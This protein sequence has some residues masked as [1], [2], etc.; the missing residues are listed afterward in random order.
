M[1]PKE[2]KLK[3]ITLLKQKGKATNTEM[4]ELLD[5]E[6]VL[7]G[8]IREELILDD[9]AEDKKGVGL[10][11][12]NQETI[13]ASDH[14]P[15]NNSLKK[16]ETDIE[17][18]FPDKHKTNETGQ[19]IF[20]SYGRQDAMEFAHKLAID[21]EHKANRQ[22]WL[23]MKSI[24]IGGMFEV[25]IEEGIR[26]SSLVLAVMTPHSLREESICRDEVVFALNEGKAVVPI[27]TG[28][29]VKPPLLLA[30]R[31]WI[32][33]SADYEE[34]FHSLLRFLNGDNL[35]LQQ[36]RL[37]SVTGV[38]PYD[39]GPEIARYTSGFT[40]REW[41][42]KEVE[43]WLINSK[44]RVLIII[45][46]P[47][48]GKSSI[49]AWISHQFR[50]QV[51]GIHFC[52]HRNTRTLNVFEFV[53]NI[54]GQL[55][56]Q[57]PEYA[58][59]VE[60][61]NPESRR[62]TASDA[63][64]ELVIEPSR[65]IVRPD[66]TYFFIVDSL[67]EAS[68]QEGENIIDVLSEQAADLPD[69]LKFFAT[70]RPE[71]NVVRKIKILNTY[72]LNAHRPENMSDVK[73]YIDNKLFELD[74]ELHFLNKIPAIS[75]AIENLAQGNFLYASLI[76]GA[77]ESKT[78]SL[79]EIGELMPGLSSY[80]DKI[81]NRIFADYK[82][83]SND[84]SVIFKVLA[85]SLGPIPA[86]L[87]LKICGF[88]PETL[89]KRLGRVKSFLRVYNYGDTQ[90]Y[91]L[92]HKSLADWLTDLNASGNYWCDPLSAFNILSD[93]LSNNWEEHDYALR[94]L[95]K[96][97]IICER[98]QELKTLITNLNFIQK[99]VVA[100][101]LYE[102]FED[103]SDTIKSITDPETNSI[104][105]DFE[106]AFRWEM[107]NLKKYPQI[108][109]QSL[110]NRLKWKGEIIA[111]I[112][113]PARKKYVESG[114]ILLNQYRIPSFEKTNIILTL[115]GHTDCVNSC[116]WSPDN[117]K[118]VTAGSDAIL[119]I[120]DV[121]NGKEVLSLP[122]HKSDVNV[123]SWSPSGF[124]IASAGND[125]FLRFWDSEKGIEIKSIPAHESI[126]T[127]LSWSPDGTR[128]VTGSYDRNL[129]IWDYQTGRLKHIL[130][131]H[132]DEINTCDWSK[133]GNIIVSA[134]KDKTIRI[135]NA[136]DGSMIKCIRGHKKN[137]LS[138]SLSPDG[139]RIATASFD[140][141]LKIWDFETGKELNSVK[142][143]DHVTNNCAWSPDGK[144]I[145]A[146]SWKIKIYL[147][148]S[149]KE[150]GILKGHTRRVNSCQWS[151][152]S[153]RIASAGDEKTLRIWDVENARIMES[154]S[155]STFLIY[156]CPWSPDGETIATGSWDKTVT[157]FEART[158]KEIKI[159]E[160]HT[161][162]VNFCSWSPMGD[163]LVSGSID[164]NLIIWDPAKGKEELVLKGHDHR[165]N[166]CKYSSDG[167]RIVS[168]GHDKVLKIWDVTSGNEIRE[169]TGH[170]EPV[171]SCSWSP[172]SKLLVSGD[173]NGMIKLWNVNRAESIKSLVKHEGSVT[174]LCWSPDGRKIISAG[175][176]K[177][178]KI[179]DPGDMSEILAFVNG[180]YY[181]TFCDLDIKGKMIVSS[182]SMD[183]SVKIWDSETGS[184]K[185]IYS[186][187][188]GIYTCSFSP[189]GNSVS[190]GD[191]VGNLYITKIEGQPEGVPIVTGVRLWHNS[192]GKNSGFYDDFLSL[193]C[194]ICMKL[195]R[196]PDR[197]SEVINSIHIDCHIIADDIPV[198]KL[199]D[200]AWDEPDLLS[201]CPKC[202]G[203]LKFNPFKVDNR[204]IWAD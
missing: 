42:K 157:L 88:T 167:K 34:G 93:S 21:L 122:G 8:K 168:G 138:C 102:M 153:K 119:K 18:N 128:I 158:G 143:S 48:I 69:W 163:R 107:H 185:G 20:I 90:S 3:L 28:S 171:M 47:G 176:D 19:R 201:E 149:L 127:C 104:L 144:K 27:Q 193:R 78:L 132:T 105:T 156:S 134:G 200:E 108:T 106:N 114:N 6:A 145:L 25:R 64:R 32:D 198:L 96:Y 81:F 196:F 66:L 183:K 151:S 129:K 187:L 70:T 120:W 39:F 61:K 162:G 1:K 95:P 31:N 125:N 109:F 180:T 2:A 111:S 63:F 80:Y 15:G 22:V 137:I 101:Y 92:F 113:E 117:K 98:W 7:F 45:G 161:W 84:F 68:L 172:D 126:I 203:K 195:I 100:G 24:E 166:V 91:S 5:G 83:Y 202:G 62:A 12:L 135:W 190:F 9:L 152:D 65:L 30:R 150:I 160:G 99:K 169:F 77:L 112:I 86:K 49:A 17:N 58:K 46:E 148:S 182:S 60:T 16:S 136:V 10:I 165:V 194:P 147:A 173:E 51:V 189:D 204:E 26:S 59:I 192:N 199:P 154:L 164:N 79:H 33:F 75:F 188:G 73:K 174:A 36:P 121:E 14:S 11:W 197:V 67:D 13:S 74:D 82:E 175:K 191:N 103:F 131:G 159:M 186:S 181:P 50:E 43:N 146:A 53:A 56:S 35:A 123:C 76:I 55:H 94:L 4:I 38:A 110:Y 97:L 37:P 140:K 177:Y 178:L 139:K 52:T 87:L 155:T 133:D 142:V 23:D 184:L 118:I 85:V 89:N 41:L 179:S 29:D 130:S 170:F 72:V 57:L 141:T 54:V 115:V 40:G 116:S 124:V 71:E 44:N